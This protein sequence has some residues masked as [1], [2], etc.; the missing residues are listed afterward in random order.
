M[1]DTSALILFFLNTCVQQYDS[2]KM[3]YSKDE[4]YACIKNIEANNFSKEDFSIIYSASL[5]CTEYLNLSSA[6]MKAVLE[7]IKSQH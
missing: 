3:K 2:S 5:F 6:E 7:N 1:S 4:L